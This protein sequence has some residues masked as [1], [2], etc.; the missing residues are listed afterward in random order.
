MDFNH[1]PA[2]STV[3]LPQ[4][5]VMAGTLVTVLS[6]YDNEW[7]FSNRMS[8]TAVAMGKLG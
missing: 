6:W 8:D 7:G 1:D 2:S 3:A 5:K 4:T